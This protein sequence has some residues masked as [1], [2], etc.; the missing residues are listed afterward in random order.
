MGTHVSPI[1]SD[2]S[3]PAGIV[4]HIYLIF[5]KIYI[6]TLFHRVLLHSDKI[7][8]PR[9]KTWKPV[10]N[11]GSPPGRTH[12][13]PPS[14]LTDFRSAAIS[15]NIIH[16]YWGIQVASHTCLQNVMPCNAQACLYSSPSK[17]QHRSQ[18]SP[19][20]EFSLSTELLQTCKA[21]PS[22]QGHLRHLTFA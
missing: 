21:T 8:V 6:M 18:T 20:W 12:G 11:P 22:Q 4:W 19:K 13:Q 17:A 16:S 14:H 15:T 7:K 10:G 3:A 2:P 9:L 5:Q 1:Q